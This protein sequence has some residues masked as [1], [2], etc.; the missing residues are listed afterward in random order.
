MP[1][2]TTTRTGLNVK[3]PGTAGGWIPSHPPQTFARP[4]GLQGQTTIKAE[5]SHPGRL[6]RPGSPPQGEQRCRRRP[7]QAAA[8]YLQV[9]RAT[10]YARPQGSQAKRTSPRVWE[11]GSR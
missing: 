2:P 6:S 3:A 9:P 8:P 10:P 1:T 11:H 4:T 5:H 7:C